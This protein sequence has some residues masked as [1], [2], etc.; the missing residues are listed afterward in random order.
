MLTTYFYCGKN[1][2]SNHALC[3]DR[4]NRNVTVS[5]NSAVL[6]EWS[7][8]C[9]VICIHNNS[10]NATYLHQTLL[11]CDVRQLETQLTGVPVPTVLLGVYFYSH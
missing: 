9:M 4:F 1:I 3:H 11:R 10:Y 5:Q 8:T 6:D 2:S 7:P